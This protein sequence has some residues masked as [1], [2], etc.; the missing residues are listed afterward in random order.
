MGELIL[1]TFVDNSFENKQLFISEE[2]Y[3]NI[4]DATHFSSLM[5]MIKSPHAYIRN[6]KN[7]KPPTERMNFGSLGHK[8][9]LEGRDFMENF[10][11]EP[12][13]KGLT[14]NGKETTSANAKSVKENALL[15][16]SRLKPGVK[17][18]SQA[19]YDS[20]GFMMES[21][22]SHK[23]V[24]EIIKDINTEVRGQYRDE[25]TSIKGVIANDILSRNLMMW[26]EF[27]TCSDSSDAG[28][29]KSVE[30]LRYDLQCFKYNNANRLIFG[31]APVEKVW[32]AIENVEPYECR[33]HWVDD[34]YLASGEYE[35][36][37]CMKLLERCL[38][39]NQW[40]QAQQVAE[41]LDPSIWFRNYYDMRI[42]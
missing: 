19:H 33:V 27:K 3:H 9:F 36:R 2:E 28:F 13:H 6:L 40:P 11:V 5:K 12:I 18:V 14:L 10:V 34:F 22:V 29:R 42:V 25:E 41:S 15:W 24:Q 23:F 39:S 4:K 7:P 8:A 1:P 30:N 37:R 21:V 38:K 31:K 32:I 35:Y 16:R 20:I 26:G 17:I